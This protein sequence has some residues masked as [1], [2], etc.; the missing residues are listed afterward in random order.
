MNPAIL[1]GSGLLMAA[2]LVVQAAREDALMKEWVGIVIDILDSYDRAPKD[3]AAQ[4][5]RERLD[6]RGRQLRKIFDT[7]PRAKQEAMLTKY[8]PQRE[9]IGKRI[10]ELL[11]KGE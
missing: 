11:S 6:A 10:L 3:P 4:K 2:L 1:V 5:E 8:L 7:W 9:A